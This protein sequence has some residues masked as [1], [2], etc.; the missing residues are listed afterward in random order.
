MP[1]Q[2]S[3]DISASATEKPGKNKQFLPPDDRLFAKP[4]FAS[5]GEKPHA[6]LEA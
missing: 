3:L 4:G 2:S 1:C 5:S 6:R